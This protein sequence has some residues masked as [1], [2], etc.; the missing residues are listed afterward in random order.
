M[1]KLTA[2][3]LV[4]LLLVISVSAQ[5]SNAK[6]TKVLL[7]GT[8]HFDN[9]GLDVAKFENADVLSARRQQEIVEVVKQLKGFNPTKIFIEATPDRQG[10]Y[11]SLLAAYKRGALQLGA[12]E[13]YQLGFRLS[14]ELNLALLL[15]VDYR[16]AVFPFDSLVKVITAANQMDQLVFM[17][18]TI[19]SIQDS[20]NQQLKTF[21]IKQMLLASNSKADR[22]FSVGMYF[23]FL[24]AGGKDNHVGSYLV[25]EWWRRNMII[26]ENILKRLNGN[27]E[28]VLVIFGSAHTALLHAFMKYNPE[29]ELV[30]IEEVL[31]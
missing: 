15:C 28:R 31:L 8:F 22:D 27:E 24:K 11:D 29:I 17:K 12:N 25:S 5:P 18:K 19:D 6:K 23:Q 2:S 26:Y 21:S 14:K 7:L 30:E 3:F 13:I 10:N 9:P 1:L 20:H 16:E 4:G